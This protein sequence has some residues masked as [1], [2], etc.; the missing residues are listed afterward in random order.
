VGLRYGL[1]IGTS[2]DV[3][4]GGAERLPAPIRSAMVRASSSFASDSHPRKTWDPVPSP[5]TYRGG[6]SLALR[7]V[8][9]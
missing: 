7:V 3:G 9:H 6:L 2:T 5:G 4:L 1:C 8:A